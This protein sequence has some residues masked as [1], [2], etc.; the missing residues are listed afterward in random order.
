MLKLIVLG[1]LGAAGYAA[2]VFFEKNGKLPDIKELGETL[3]SQ[4]GKEEYRP[5]AMPA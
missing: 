4:L 5:G 2:Y 1:A 3:K